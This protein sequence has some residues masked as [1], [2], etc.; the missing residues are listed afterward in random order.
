M[1]TAK[2][3]SKSAAKPTVRPP[4]PH[5]QDDVAL[6]DIVDVMALTRMSSSWVHAA[7]AGGRFPAPVIRQPRCS[8]WT[9]ASIRKWLIEQVEKASVDTAAAKRA[10]AR[11]RKASAAAKHA[12]AA[13]VADNTP[14]TEPPKVPPAKASAPR[15]EKRLG[16]EGAPL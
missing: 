11:A 10:A 16:G 13:K 7:V 4:L 14:I 5:G 9:L 15:K 12:R 8:R 1:T 3:Q 2:T 6:V